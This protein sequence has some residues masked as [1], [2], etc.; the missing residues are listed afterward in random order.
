MTGRR[1]FAQGRRQ[2]P[3]IRQRISGYDDDGEAAHNG[4]DAAGERAVM[5]LRREIV[6]ARLGRGES[7][8]KR[9]R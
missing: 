4:D 1:R 2:E 6:E 9:R 7:T 3:R 5:Y 8:G